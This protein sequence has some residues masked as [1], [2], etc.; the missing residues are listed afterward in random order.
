[1]VPWWRVGWWRGGSLVASWLVARFPG[2]EMTGNPSGFLSRR[3]H[4]FFETPNWLIDFSD[5][6]VGLHSKVFLPSD[7]LMDQCF[8]QEWSQEKK[9]ARD[10]CRGMCSIRRHV[11]IA[12]HITK[13]NYLV[14]SSVYRLVSVD[15]NA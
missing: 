10:L 13:F 4:V 1:M 6:L 11:K 9:N 7:G 12:I 14:T 8:P 5:N 3:A 15:T 2:G